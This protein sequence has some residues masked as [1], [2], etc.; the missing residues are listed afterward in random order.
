MQVDRQNG[1]QLGLVLLP[2]Q[3]EKST[4]PTPCMEGEEV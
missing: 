3:R 2:W 1:G 4:V